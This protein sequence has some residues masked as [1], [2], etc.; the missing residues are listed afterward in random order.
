MYHHDGYGDARPSTAASDGPRR[1]ALDF[2]PSQRPSVFTG[3]AKVLVM[4]VNLVFIV[5]AGMLIYFTVWVKNIGVTK[6]FQSNYAWVTNTMFTV[7]LVFGVVVLVVSLLGCLGAWA[8][9]RHMLLVYTAG[10]VINFFLFGAI[11]FGGFYSLSTA[12]SWYDKP[13][14]LQPKEDAVAKEFDSMYCKGQVAYYCS[15]GSV[16]KSLNLFLQD[17]KLVTM[18]TP[19]FSQLQ[20]WNQMCNS[21]QLKITDTNLATKVNET[22]ALCSQF[23]YSDYADFLT[24]SEPNC[25]LD[26]VSTAY[27]VQYL[28]NM[29]TPPSEFFKGAPYGQCRAN[30]L[31]LW[32]SVSRVLA[33]GGLIVAIVSL[34]ILITSLALRRTVLETSKNS[35]IQ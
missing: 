2:D 32:K 22:C 20:G 31:L 10:L 29:T 1:S 18:A 3:V 35:I 25:P 16:S 19:I 5:I 4:L 12:S 23:A 17:P 26:A 15:E 24:W 7:L 30:F 14:T 28:G 13:D 8:R 34:S 27:C 9:N 21:T 6:M 11:T 33:Y